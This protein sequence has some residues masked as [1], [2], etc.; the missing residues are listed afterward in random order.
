M[1]IFF[2]LYLEL[3]LAITTTISRSKN[4]FFTVFDGKTG[5]AGKYLTTPFPGGA[6]TR[7]KCSDVSSDLERGAAVGVAVAAAGIEP[8]AL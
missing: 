2:Q 6:V 4:A 7:K 8:P 5:M 3:L 1:A